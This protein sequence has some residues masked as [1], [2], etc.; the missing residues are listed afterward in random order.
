MYESQN[1]FRMLSL[2]SITLIDTLDKMYWI[3]YSKPSINKKRVFA[4]KSVRE[5]LNIVRSEREMVRLSNLIGLPVSDCIRTIELGKI[6]PAHGT[7][8]SSIQ[9]LTNTSHEH[10]LCLSSLKGEFQIL[11]IKDQ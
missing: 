1:L 3:K 6:S 5:P 4:T 11:V 2:H 8:Y 10:T 9:T 7:I